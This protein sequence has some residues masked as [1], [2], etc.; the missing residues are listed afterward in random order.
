MKFSLPYSVQG[1]PVKI[2][3]SPRRQVWPRTGVSGDGGCP[4]PLALTGWLGTIDGGAHL[5]GNQHVSL[6][7][8]I[9][10]N[11]A[12]IR[13]KIWSNALPSGIYPPQ[14]PPLCVGMASGDLE[15]ELQQYNSSC[16]S[17][18]ARAPSRRFW[19][20]SFT[21][22]TAEYEVLEWKHQRLETQNQCMTEKKAQDVSTI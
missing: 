20:G 14:C 2:H 17:C 4:G 1:K 8:L 7:Y 5:Q 18:V 22:M 13:T 6:V 12:A 11:L 9:E 15:P 19:R 10:I 21:S 16:I 3:N